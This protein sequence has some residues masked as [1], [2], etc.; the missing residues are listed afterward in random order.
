MSYEQWFAYPTYRP[1][2]RLMLES[3]E[4]CVKRGEHCVLMIDAPTGSGKTSA[5]SAVLSAKGTRRVVIAL[6]TTSQVEAYLSEIRRIRERTGRMPTIAYLVGKPKMCPLAREFESPYAGCELLRILTKNALEARMRTLGRERYDV[7]EDAVL[8]ARMESEQAGDRSMCPYYAR[9]KSA[10]LTE[11]GVAFLPSDAALKDAAR[12]TSEVLSPSQLRRACPLTCPYEV[13]ALS[14][15]HADVVVLN[16]HHVL[17]ERMRDAMFGWLGIEPEESILVVDE[18]HNAGSAVRSINS[19]HIDVRTTERALSELDVFLKSEDARALRDDVLA[20]KGVLERLKRYVQAAEGRAS[21]EVL[22]PEAIMNSVLG[23]VLERADERV[24]VSILDLSQA[25]KQHKEKLSE[26][27]EVRLAKVA[28]FLRMCLVATKSDACIVAKGE[29]G[30]VWAGEI[31]PSPH[32]R[33]L[34]DSMS[35]TIMLSGTLSPLPAYELYFFAQENR[36]EKLSLTNSFPAEN[37]LVLVSKT[38]TTLSSRR[39]DAHNV[40]EI[41]GHLRGLI[42]G[43]EGNV[44]LYFTS[45]GMLEQYRAFCEQCARGAGKRLFCE[46]REARRIPS[47][48]RDFFACATDGGA[49]MLAVC[50]GKLSE[51]IDYVG[52]SLKGA[53]VIGLPLSAYTGVQRRI[54]QYYVR[55]YGRERGMLLAYTLPALNRAMQALGRVLR[56]EHDTG[57][58][59]LCDSRFASP[60]VAQHLPTWLKEEMV[61]VDAEDSSLISQWAK[62]RSTA[63]T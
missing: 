14:A 49:V 28:E 45:Y 4:R 34:V 62:G 1:N 23:E 25:I 32:L 60:N 13:M 55:R 31:D 57:V 61:M 16:Y 36:A 2:Q 20:A 56:S 21:E 59:M 6:R 18:A 53:A 29:E 44:A 37:R 26:Y 35:C 48:L 5:I 27:S 42:E 41:K 51:G 17:D 50:G 58:L 54:N 15:R 38:A 7:D 3:V 24:V 9:S 40:S 10:V 30:R 63:H 12:I 43:V 8:R 33:R 47:L 39:T 19:V 46:P 22:D 52:S 11:D